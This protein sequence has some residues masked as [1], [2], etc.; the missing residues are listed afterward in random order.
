[1]RIFGNRRLH[2]EHDIRRRVQHRRGRYYLR[3]RGHEHRIGHVRR[4]TRAHLDENL[5]PISQQ[6]R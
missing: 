4:C 5:M 2:L 3:S 1:L 6:R